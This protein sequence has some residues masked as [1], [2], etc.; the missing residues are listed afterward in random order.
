MK[1]QR[2]HER[3]DC[4]G[5]A[6]IHLYGIGQLCRAR[7]ENLSLRGC[8][9]VLRQRPKFDLQTLFELTFTVHELSFRVRGRVTQVRGP[10]CI[11]V[12]FVDLRPRLKR[13]LEDLIEELAAGGWTPMWMDDEVEGRDTG[14]A[15]LFVIRDSS[16]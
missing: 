15:Q 13:Y 16:L 2:K 7:I 3:F 1:E 14:R 9:L 5:M 12:E 11:G 10:R 8:K 6:E 4:E